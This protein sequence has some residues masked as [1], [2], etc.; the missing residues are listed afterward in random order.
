MPAL[1][2]NKLPAE[3][4][5]FVWDAALLD[6]GKNRVVLVD[7]NFSAIYPTKLL[8]SPFLLVSHESRERAKR[9]Y[10]YRVDVN[11]V[12]KRDSFITNSLLFGSPVGNVY[13]SAEYDTFCGGFK[14][15]DFVD[16]AKYPQRE[17]AEMKARWRGV[18]FCGTAPEILYELAPSVRKACIISYYRPESEDRTSWSYQGQGYSPQNLRFGNPSRDDLSVFL[19]HRKVFPNAQ[20]LFEVYI[21]AEYLGRFGSF[22]RICNSTIDITVIAEKGWEGYLQLM[23]LFPFKYAVGRLMNW[24]DWRS[25]C[26]RSGERVV[27]RPRFMTLPEFGEAI[28]V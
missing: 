6:E 7:S 26:D 11:E 19:Q 23:N 10:S 21:P 22:A 3:L 17:F 20:H 16:Q 25:W 15:P 13:L 27:P 28:G 12:T 1:P 24:Q 2:F 18:S 8:V 5:Q 9:F 4:R 14:W